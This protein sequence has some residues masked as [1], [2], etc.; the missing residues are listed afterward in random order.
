MRLKKLKMLERKSHKN[1]NQRSTKM[2]KTYPRVPNFSFLC[3]FL[4][5]RD[6]SSSL[7][8]FL[9]FCHFFTVIRVSDSINNILTLYLLSY[10]NFQ[11]VVCHFPPLILHSR[12]KFVKLKY[13]IH[14]I[15]ILKL[16]AKKFVKLNGNLG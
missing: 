12:T 3:V 10:Y 8:D 6:L 16:F 4:L 7:S 15:T 11:C 1:P 14:D 5:I 9:S 13:R 2:T